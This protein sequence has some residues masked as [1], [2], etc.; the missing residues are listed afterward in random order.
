MKI[1]EIDKMLPIKFTEFSDG[2]TIKSSVIS[3]FF[4][5]AS[6]FEET[7]G[8]LGNYTDDYLYFPSNTEKELES[9]LLD[10]DII[11]KPERFERHNNNVR[12]GDYTRYWLGDGYR[13]FYDA[14][15][16]KND[17]VNIKL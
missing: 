9:I 7:I 3:I 4:D 10:Y 15:W 6:D 11:R 1:R 13:A 2:R 12:K 5:E 8:E 17:I 16:G 14:W